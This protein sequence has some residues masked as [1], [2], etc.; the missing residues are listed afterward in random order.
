M[1]KNRNSIRRNQSRKSNT[2][3]KINKSH[4]N[5]KKSRLHFFNRLKQTLKKKFANKWKG[6]NKD[7]LELLSNLNDTIH[8][9]SFDNATETAHNLTVD[10]NA[11]KNVAYAAMDAADRAEANNDK[12]I[13]EIL[14]SV[15]YLRG[16][17]WVD[18]NMFAF[19][20]KPIPPDNMRLLIAA[21]L[22][23]RLKRIKLDNPSTH[24]IM[25]YNK[26]IE[27]VHHENGKMHGID[28]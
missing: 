17:D 5:S 15:Y 19:H 16:M 12:N 27:F 6:G 7:E 3:R 25:R 23:S 2:R 10:M 1:N 18:N 22:A 13:G 28:Y 11:I 21:T 24:N 4:K 26:A 8:P 14:Q 20:R 9:I